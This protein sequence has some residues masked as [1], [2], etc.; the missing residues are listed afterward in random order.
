MFSMMKSLRISCD[1]CS[2]TFS[3]FV[4]TSDIIN[5]I[6]GITPATTPMYKCIY[7]AVVPSV[8]ELS[9]NASLND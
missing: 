6:I 2:N 8:S 5:D 3:N 1:G 7:L 9:P 4:K